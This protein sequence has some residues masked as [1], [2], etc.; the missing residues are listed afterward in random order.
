MRARTLVSGSLLL[1][2]TATVVV[3]DVLPPG[4]KP[5]QPPPPSGPQNAVVRGVE[6]ANQY[7]YWRGRR[8]LT[9]I[10]GCPP[11]TPT[12]VAGCIVE[13]IAGKDQRV[14]SVA[15]VVAAEKAAANAPLELM[16]VACSSGRLVLPAPATK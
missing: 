15:D 9:R 4:P 13:G 1:C 6:I 16:L 8:W 7:G 5:P 12:C 14:Q 10:T 2:L 11:A 3:A